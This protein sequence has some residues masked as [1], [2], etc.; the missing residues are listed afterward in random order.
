[1]I[2]RKIKH[3]G[4]NWTQVKLNDDGSIPEGFAF[5]KAG[6]YEKKLLEKLNK[7]ARLAERPEAVVL[8]ESNGFVDVEANYIEIIEDTESALDENG[9]PR[10]IAKR[11]SEYPSVQEMIVALWEKLVE[12]R[13]ESANALQAKREQV[14]Q[15]YPKG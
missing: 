9:I 5:I 14:K 6:R 10:Y 8:S 11:A 1:M 15:K 13:P 7:E 12:G 3:K 2:I 4:D